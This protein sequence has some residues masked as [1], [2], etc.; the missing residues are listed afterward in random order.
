M[1]CLIAAVLTVTFLLPISATTAATEATDS[2]LSRTL[3]E[4]RQGFPFDWKRDEDLDSFLRQLRARA[5]VAIVW[6]STITPGKTPAKTIDLTDQDLRTALNTIAVV[7]SRYSWREF[8]G[9][10]VV[11]PA[12]AW[13][14]ALNPLN[15]RVEAIE[16]PDVGP[17]EIVL[18]SYHL[19]LGEAI[20]EASVSAIKSTTGI[21]GRMRPRFSISVASGSSV[22]DML[23]AVA[24][25]HRQIA[26]SAKYWDTAR[27]ARALT[28]EYFDKPEAIGAIAGVGRH[29][30]LPPSLTGS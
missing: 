15:Q 1:R 2:V 24:R 17:D 12:A 5:D 6:E 30:L 13:S 26:W 23:I 21:D 14:N 16:W 4:W 7:D 29:I 10:I 9:V 8:D 25:P 28:L 19:I 11:R 18:R 22:L 27:K 20:D 3:P